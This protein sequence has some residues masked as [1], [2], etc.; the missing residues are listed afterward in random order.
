MS[1]RSAGSTSWPANW[2][3]SAFCR[4]RPKSPGSPATAERKPIRA[5]A[6]GR[7]FGGRRGANPAPGRPLL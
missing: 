3:N 2:Q 6:R 7:L 1:G 4:R 5:L